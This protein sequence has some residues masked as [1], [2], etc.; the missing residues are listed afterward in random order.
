MKGWENRFYC[1]QKRAEVK[2]EN[3]LRQMKIKTQNTKIMGY[4][5]NN[6][7]RE[8]YSSDYV[9]KMGRFQRNNLTLYFEELDKKQMKPEVSE[10]K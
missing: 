2:L 6:I 8:V 3:I 9:K 7:E 4:S 5:S 10:R 1:N